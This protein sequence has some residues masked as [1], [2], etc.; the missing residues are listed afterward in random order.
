MENTNAMEQ[1]LTDSKRRTA[2]ARITA[3]AA[4]GVFVVVVAVC[5]L[6]VPRMFRLMNQTDAMVTSAETAIKEISE[7]TANITETS[8]SLND[9]LT[10][11]SQTI[12]DAISGIN[13]VDIATL[14]EAIRNLKDAV[15]PFAN[16]MNRFK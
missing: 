12:S 7:M 6:T 1:L 13:G 16:L 14:N 10:D 3:F 9:F 11:N 5:I 15:E 4:V 8:T 2:Y